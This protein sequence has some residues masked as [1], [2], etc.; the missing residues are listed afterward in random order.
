MAFHPHYPEGYYGYYEAS[1]D[2]EW[3]FSSS[4][5][6]YPSDAIQYE[7]G[8]FSNFECYPAV[9]VPGCLAYPAPYRPRRPIEIL[10][11]RS[12][13][14]VAVSSP[15]QLVYPG[16]EWGQWDRTPVALD[17]TGRRSKKILEIVDPEKG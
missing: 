11:P 10:D 17:P 12:G 13:R 8:T 1:Q 4:D 16:N 2:Q 9:R 3:W 14:A 7:S 5:D 15:P 6:E